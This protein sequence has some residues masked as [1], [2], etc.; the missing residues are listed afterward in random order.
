MAER[1]NPD[2]F[3]QRMLKYA[4]QKT[5]AF[6]MIFVPGKLRRFLKLQLFPRKYR[7][8]ITETEAWRKECS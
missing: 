7:T 5:S 3:Q 8:D 4:L 2:A 1:K 6:A